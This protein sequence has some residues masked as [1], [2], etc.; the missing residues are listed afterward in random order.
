MDTVPLG[1]GGTFIAVQGNETLF[2]RDFGSIVPGSDEPVDRNT[3]FMGGTLG[4]SIIAALAMDLHEQGKLNLS[5]EVVNI[6]HDL[7]FDFTILERNITVEDLLTHRSGMET[8]V[9]GN[10]VESRDG[11]VDLHEFLRKRLPRIIWQPGTVLSP[12]SANYAL[13]A[14]VME[15]ITGM[16]FRDYAQEMFFAPA[17]MNSSG[18]SSDPPI[19]K[20]AIGITSHGGIVEQNWVNLFPTYGFYTTPQDLEQ[21]LKH[22]NGRLRFLLNATTFM[23]MGNRTTWELPLPDYGFGFAQEY[24]N[25]TRMLVKIG[26]TKG[27]SSAIYMDPERNVTVGML[28]NREN[29]VMFHRA[30]RV[31]LKHFFPESMHPEEFPAYKPEGFFSLR[32]FTGIYRETD[33]IR[34]TFEKSLMIS[35]SKTLKQEPLE[36]GINTREDRL[37]SEFTIQEVDFKYTWDQINE[38]VFVQHNSTEFIVF[39]EVGDQL[40]IYTSMFG[41]P[42]YFEKIPFLQ[43]DSTQLGLLIFSESLFGIGLLSVFMVPKFRKIYFNRKNHLMDRLPYGIMVQGGS[44]NIIFPLVFNSAVESIPQ[45]QFVLDIPILLKVLLLIPIVS[46]FLF[47]TFSTHLWVARKDL[48]GKWQRLYFLLYAFSQLVYIY[49]L[50]NL[51]LLGYQY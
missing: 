48:G 44:L 12:S 45:T 27:F 20:S 16:D 39:L 46:V 2:Q 42:Q 1:S 6:I 33:F 35:T 7:P 14:L 19:G 17:G 24:I 30:I 49:V 13:V 51:N 43:A 37:T 25:G 3:F 47:M 31:F 18:F 50:A 4:E 5:E 8:I 11:I 32:K 26:E 23:A 21:L 9:F 29:A 22:L 38:T 40:F 41:M 28:V 10:W 34:S 15:N 36:I